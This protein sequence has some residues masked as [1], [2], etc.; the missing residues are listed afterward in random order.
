MA[1][2]LAAA[3]RDTGCP[4]DIA[5]RLSEELR[6]E[7]PRGSREWLLMLNNHGTGYPLDRGQVAY[8]AE[9]LARNVASDN[10][11]AGHRT[12]RGDSGGTPYWPLPGRAPDRQ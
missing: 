6:V 10:A 11:E 4:P 3:L 7:R 8:A 9:H 2:A 1:E 12:G 5:E